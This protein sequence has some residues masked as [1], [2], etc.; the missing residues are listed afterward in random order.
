MIV[1]T[2]IEDIWQ[3]AETNSLLVLSRVFL[4][5][6]ALQQLPAV[7]TSTHISIF[8]FPFYISTHILHVPFSCSAVAVNPKLQYAVVEV[9][10][11]SGDVSTVPEDG[12]KRL[13][14]VLKEQKKPFLIIASDLLRT[15]EEKWGAKL[16]VQKILL[17]S[18]LENYKL[19]PEI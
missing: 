13:G 8:H 3:M 19:S 9:H 6:L 1:C 4:L 14:N 2:T 17:G 15:L 18:D 5:Q 12:K 16:V 7:A 10:E 11:R